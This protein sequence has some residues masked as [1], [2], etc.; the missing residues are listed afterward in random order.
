M[1]PN[2]SPTLSPKEAPKVPLM[3][4]WE[5]VPGSPGLLPR[6]GLG[7][8][9]HSAVQLLM[10]P[11]HVIGLYHVAILIFNRGMYLCDY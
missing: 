9:L 10:P 11:L 3:R 5:I 8:L 4:S 6:V 1:V 7:L 2:I